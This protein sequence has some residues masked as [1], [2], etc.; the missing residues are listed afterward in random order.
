MYVYISACILYYIMGSTTA[1]VRGLVYSRGRRNPYKA[2]SNMTNL[3]T[4]TVDFTPRYYNANDIN[5]IH[6][7]SIYCV[8]RQNEYKIKQ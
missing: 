6:R 2:M 8:R 4:Y 7:I 3:F 5:D 1:C